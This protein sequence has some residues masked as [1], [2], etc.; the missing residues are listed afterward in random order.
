V[1]ITGGSGYLGQFLVHA[2]H[3]S[4]KVL[5]A[6]ACGTGILLRRSNALCTAKRWQQAQHSVVTHHAPSVIWACVPT[7][8][9]VYAYGSRTLPSANCIAAG[10]KVR[11]TL[12]VC[13]SQ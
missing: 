5:A 13:S 10:V 8:Q 1:L 4:C 9:V 3:Q 6:R 11:E 7:V 2:L 12:I